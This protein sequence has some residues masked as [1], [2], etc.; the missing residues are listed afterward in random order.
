MFY[1]FN[2]LILALLL[3]IQCSDRGN[4][5]SIDIQPEI[6]DFYDDNIQPI[7]SAS[8]GGGCHIGGSV[9]GLD[10]SPALSYDN[11]IFVGATGY[12]GSVR[13][14]P[15]DAANSVL[16]NKIANTGVNG[17]Q[18]PPGGPLLSPT[19]ISLIEDWI[20]DGAPFQ[21]EYTEGE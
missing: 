1:K 2:S 6:I 7:F 15:N 13:V 4:P 14:A 18:M 5:A 17:Q 19:Q 10:L 3:I 12:S 21:I 11:L 8:C 20:N 9:G 16:F